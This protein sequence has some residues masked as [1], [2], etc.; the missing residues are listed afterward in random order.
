MRSVDYIWL[1][2]PGFE[3]EGNFLYILESSLLMRD[4]YECLISSVQL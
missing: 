3:T 1:S 4:S 2:L